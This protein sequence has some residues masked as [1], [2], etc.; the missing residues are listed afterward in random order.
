MT[1]KFEKIVLF[2]NDNNPQ[3]FTCFKDKDLKIPV[4]KQRKFHLTVI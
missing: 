1:T 3:V 4:K 2:D